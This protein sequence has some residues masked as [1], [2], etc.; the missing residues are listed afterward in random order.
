MSIPHFASRLSFVQKYGGIFVFLSGI[1]GA[2][3]LFAFLWMTLFFGVREASAA[4]STD[5]CLAF[6]LK[7]KTT[8][9]LVNNVANSG[10]FY[11]D[12]ASAAGVKETVYFAYPDQRPCALPVRDSGDSDLKTWAAA[13][14]ALDDIALKGWV[15]NSNFGWTSLYCPGADGDNLGVYC[16]DQKYGVTIDP[17]GNFRGYAWSQ[18]GWIRFRCAPTQGYGDSNHCAKSNYGVSADLKSLDKN[19]YASAANSY[20]AT[21]TVGWM[22][23][24]GLMI[25]VKAKSSPIDQ[26]PFCKPGD[27]SCPVGC[28]P[29]L[30]GDGFCT[31]TPAI[32]CPGSGGCPG[33]SPGPD[34]DDNNPFVTPLT[35]PEIPPSSPD[36]PAAPVVPLPVDPAA[37][38]SG[39]TFNIP[40]IIGSANQ[41]GDM[42]SV[43]G[44]VRSDVR[45]V[46]YRNVQKLKRGAQCGAIGSILSFSLEDDVF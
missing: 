17:N 41:V 32:T 44:S 10:V 2:F 33:G 13:N 25:P 39:V 46:I 8:Q 27:I 14:G 34:P 11:F 1:A 38:T 26:G 28:K 6:P 16:G 18:V 29:D 9:V 12:P 4:V 40:Q 15:W 20:A 23:F 42:V 43:G 5:P 30:D 24:K 19:G 3:L 21:N 35:P 36:N 31:M 45:N 22:N 7:G 37:A